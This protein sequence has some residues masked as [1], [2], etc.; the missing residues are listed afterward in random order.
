LNLVASLPQFPGVAI[1]WI[2]NNQAAV[3]NGGVV[4]R[5]EKNDQFVSLT[6]TLSGSVTGTKTYELI[7]RAKGTDNVDI[8]GYV[9]PYFVDGYP[10]AYL[11][12]G[13][14]SVRYKL[15]APAEV[16]MVVNSINGSWES[17][18]KAVLEGRAGPDNDII[19]VD[20]WPYFKME[21]SGVNQLQEFDTDVSIWGQAAR[22]EF[23]IR[24]VSSNYTSSAVTTVLFDQETISALDTFPPRVYG[25]FVNDDMS[26]IY[27]YFNEKIDLTSVPSSADFQLN[28]GTVNNVVL[29][30]YDE[31]YGL[32]NSYIKLLVSGIPAEQKNA[33]RL[34]YTGTAIQDLSD[35]R[36][37]AAAFSSNSITADD[38][39]VDKVTISSDRKSMIVDILPG[40]NPNDNKQINLMDVSRYMITIGGQSYNPSAVNYGYSVGDLSFKLKFATPLPAGTVSVKVNTSGI[41][42][43]SKDSYPGEI[44]SQ[45][46]TEIGAPGTPT[47]SYAGG[48]ITLTYAS[49]FEFGTSST[50]VGFVIK[51]DN[52]EYALR[53]FITRPNWVDGNVR[54]IDLNDKYSSHF[55]AAVDS[56][57]TIEIKYTKASGMEVNLP[58]DS[59]GA[60]LPDFD[61]ITV[62][63]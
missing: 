51:V 17:S 33:L 5:G 9:D 39:L 43:W 41:V 3:T 56:G 63:K 57:S 46:I 23:V 40:W 53:G 11:K 42:D 45:A 12:D 29:Y 62:T 60:V 52:V 15:S 34:S 4:T 16:Y 35:A 58:S 2:S 50:A 19:N 26:A 18:V 7:V 44:S 48:I 30:N 13:K 36:N 54:L 37:K 22:V 59:A 25:S 20:S 28:Y 6:A 10:Q 49:G 61:Y 27:V 32:V 55:K 24:D 21:S 38:A 1:S 8:V 14:I 47:A 31:R